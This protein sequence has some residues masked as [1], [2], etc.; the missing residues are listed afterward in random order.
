M[1]FT[2]TF[3]SHAFPTLLVEFGETVSYKAGS[4]EAVDVTAF[5]NRDDLDPNDGEDGRSEK[6]TATV[7]ISTAEIAS[8][9]RGDLITFDSMT[10]AVRSVAIR[11]TVAT[12][13]VVYSHLQSAR[14]KHR[15]IR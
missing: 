8:P 14:N 11:G 15:M 9:V 5:V 2:D 4:A 1:P 10:F 7:S 6:Q 12:L 13:S 3:D